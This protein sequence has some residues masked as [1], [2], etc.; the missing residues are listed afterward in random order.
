MKTA[1]Y[2]RV[3]TDTQDLIQ[4]IRA[5]RKFCDYKDFEV[6]KIYC[7]VGSGKDYFKRTNYNKMLEDLRAMKY[8][9]VVTFR[10]DRLGRNAVEAV[11]FFEEM[12][13]KGISIFSLNENLDTSTAIGRA[14]RDIIVRLAQLERESISEA[15]KH[16]LEAL[17]A[18]G[19][20]L[21]RPKGSKD[22]KTRKK[23]GY[24]GNHNA[25][26]K[27]GSKNPVAE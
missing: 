5:C 14:V 22:T 20:T 8:G 12:E 4:Q 26:K 7:D 3:S 9:G 27:R 15:T 1:I 10:F 21:G 2:C 25:T 17:R 24:Y 18:L 11:R 23:A 6:G 16:R 13:N 19:K